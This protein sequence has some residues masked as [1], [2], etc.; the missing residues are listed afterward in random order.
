MRVNGEKVRQVTEQPW[1]G[2]RG[3]RPWEDRRVLG[4]G[5]SVSSKPQV[6]CEVSES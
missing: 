1:R 5:C 6:R 3:Y 4:V 2:T